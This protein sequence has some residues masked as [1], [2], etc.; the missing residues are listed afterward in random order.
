MNGNDSE[1]GHNITVKEGERLRDKETGKI[2]IVKTVY[3]AEVLLQGENGRG[4]RIASLN[5][6]LVTCDKLE[7]KA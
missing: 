1:K 6:L 3:R 4:R 7:D 5:N 2:Y